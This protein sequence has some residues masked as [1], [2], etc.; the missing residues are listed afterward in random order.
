MCSVLLSEQILYFALYSINRSVFITEV[1]SVYYA[2]RAEYLYKTI[3]FIFKGLIRGH[4]DDLHEPNRRGFTTLIFPGDGSKFS[5][6]NIKYIGYLLQ[7]GKY[8]MQYSCN[9]SMI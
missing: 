6:R 5:F 4:K 8:S 7:N 1:H 3:R 9:E 2:V